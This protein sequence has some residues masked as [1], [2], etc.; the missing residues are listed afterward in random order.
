M[1]N[2]DEPQKLWVLGQELLEKRYRGR[3]EHSERAFETHHGALRS[4]QKFGD[5]T[6]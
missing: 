1:R 3:R 6:N 2:I 4:E 5:Q